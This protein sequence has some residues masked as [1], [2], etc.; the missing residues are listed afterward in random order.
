MVWVLPGIALLVAL[1][2]AV[3]SWAPNRG[4]ARDR[5]ALFESGLTAACILMAARALVDW[6]A[7]PLA[8]WYIAVVAVAGGAVGAILRVT[9]LPALA[10]PAKS[11]ARAVSAGLTVLV[12][13]GLL[14]LTIL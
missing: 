11:T 10:N 1:S 13:L 4:A 5:L 12:S 6:S 7:V 14:C 9:S 8:L 3:K 2:F